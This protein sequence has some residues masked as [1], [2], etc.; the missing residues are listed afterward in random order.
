MNVTQTKSVIENT[1]SIFNST[2]A[3]TSLANATGRSKLNLTLMNSSCD[4]TSTNTSCLDLLSTTTW[5]NISGLSNI[6]FRAS[7]NQSLN[8]S[9]GI[10]NGLCPAGSYCPEGTQY[11]ILCP[12]GTYLSETSISYPGAYACDCLMCP[13]GFYCNAG[14]SSPSPCPRGYFCP[15]PVD[16]DQQNPCNASNSCGKY[17]TMQICPAGTYQ[18]LE[19]QAFAQSCKICGGFVGNV[20]YLGYYCPSPGATE[21]TP[22]P[23]GQF[24]Y[25]GV[26]VS[27]ACSGG[28][29]RQKTSG[30]GNI[31]CSLCPASY[32]CGSGT[33]NPVPCPGGRYCKAGSA[34]ATVCPGGFFCPPNSSYPYPCPPG[35]YCAVGSWLPILCPIGSYCLAFSIIPTLCPLGTYG[36]SSSNLNRSAIAAAC[37]NCPKGFYGD[38]AERLQC[39]LCFAGYLCYGNSSVHSYGTTRGDPQDLSID[40]GE[41]CPPGYFCGSG[42]FVPNP[43]P[44]GSFNA[45]PAAVD[46]SSCV[47]CPTNYFNNRTGQA[48]CQPCGSTS[49]STSNRTECKCKGANRVFQ[50]SDSACRCAFGYV[51]YDSNGN[52]TQQG[53]SD[54]IADCDVRSLPRCGSNI[55]GQ[56]GSCVES[57]SD[58]SC[59]LPPC[60]CKSGTEVDYCNGTCASFQT[61]QA[62]QIQV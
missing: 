61:P 9:I 10:C 45:A 44:T 3:R 43:C 31:S 20:S 49:Y 32:F 27:F 47:P 7:Q 59:P 11:P 53:F 18:P 57:C 40:G 12:A 41:P 26:P 29:Y 34:Y 50:Q 56:D 52:P 54:G 35:Y 36:N 51:I 13:Q 25:S 60:F 39:D 33:I 21:Q 1:S 23:A 22:C 28:T 19:R 6:T 8:A 15:P 16:V 5:Q 62:Q 30:F 58:S 2:N 14:C 46:N 55:R 42:S 24:C 4:R 37:I 48:A 17:P 38:D